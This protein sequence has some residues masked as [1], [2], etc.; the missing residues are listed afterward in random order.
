[1]F[2]ALSRSVG[3]FLIFP[4]TIQF[5]EEYKLFENLRDIKPKILLILKKWSWL[6]LLPLGTCIYLLINYHITGDALYFLKMEEK[7]WFQNT[8]VFYETIRKPLEIFKWRKWARP[9]SRLI[10]ASSYYDFWNIW[11]YDIFH[12]KT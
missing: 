12:S 7:H 9:K 2:A 4:A 8:Q 5:I 1:M 6:L 10:C 11:T 3:V